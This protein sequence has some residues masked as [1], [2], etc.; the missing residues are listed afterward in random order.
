VGPVLLTC[1]AVASSLSIQIPHCPPGNLG[2]GS[3]AD[4]VSGEPLC[5][6]CGPAAESPQLKLGCYMWRLSKALLKVVSS[7]RLVARCSSSN[8]RR[9]ALLRTDSRWETEG[10]EGIILIAPSAY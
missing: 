2:R 9:E 3:N 1:T 7:R 5:E 4:Q 10:Y 8:N 6:C